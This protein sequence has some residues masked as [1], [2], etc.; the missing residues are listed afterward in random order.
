ML[1]EDY[2]NLRDRLIEDGFIEA[3]PVRWKKPT[4]GEVREHFISKKR[5]CSDAD[6]FYNHWDSV[7][8]YTK[9]KVRIKSW[10]GRAATWIGNNYDKNNGSNSKGARKLSVSEQVA[11]GINARENENTTH[12][13][14]SGQIVADYG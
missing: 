5:S 2:F 9:G 3:N 14:E 1:D 12:S 8:W 13:E 6:K 4:I 7:D 11:A 10:R